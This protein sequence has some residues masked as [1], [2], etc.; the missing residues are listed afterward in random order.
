MLSPTC[1]H[2]GPDADP[3][4]ADLTDAQRQ[5]VVHGGGPLLIVAG[6]GSGKT[7]TIT[8]RIAYLVRGG[9]PPWA[10]LALTF[11][12]K[13]AGEMRARVA[14]LLGDDPAVV[15]GLIVTTFHSLCARLLRQYADGAGVS[16][17]R[18]GFSIYDESDQ[19]AVMKRVLED[20]QLSPGNWSPRSMLAAISAAKNELVD[21]DAFAAGADGFVQKRVAEI[22]RRY[23]R[24]LRS[25]NALDF[26]DLLVFTVRLLRDRGEVLEACRRRW[27]HVLIDEYQ[28]VNRAQFM[29]AAML[30]GASP[31]PAVR[32][33]PHPPNI[34]VVGDSD[35]AIY[36][37]RGADIRNILDFE[38]HFPGARV[39]TLGENFR[40]TGPILAAADRLIRHNRMRRH[41]TLFT[42]QAG[43]EPPRVMLCADEHDEARTVVQWLSELHQRGSEAGRSEGY[44]WRDMA[45]LY[46]VN[47]L[48]R[49]MEEALRQAGIPYVIVRGTAFYEREEVRNILA[50]LRVLANPADDVSLSRIVNV[51]ARGLGEVAMRTLRAQAEARGVSLMEALHRAE[52]RQALGPRGG[53]A[54]GR[55]VSLFEAWSRAAACP[56]DDSH[57]LAGLVER[58]VQ[59]SGLEA[60][61]ARQARVGRAETDRERL[62]N[63]AEVISSAAD[64]EQNGDWRSAGE[65]VEPDSAGSPEQTG[66]TVMTALRAY[67]ES[68]ALVS[69]ADAIDPARGA[70]TLMT[71]HAAK[72]LEF[73]VVAMI[74]LEEGLLPHAR[75]QDDEAAL[76]EERR[77]CFV[78]MTR[79]MRHLHLSAA[80]C[81]TVRGQSEAMLPSR[82]LEEMGAA[83]PA[84]PRGCEGTGRHGTRHGNKDSAD[85]MRMRG[86]MASAGGARPTDLGAPPWRWVRVGGLVRH[87]KFGIGR[88][89]AVTP[90][91]DARARVQFKSAGVRTLVLRYAPL[92]AVE[93][94]EEVAGT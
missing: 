2:T 77:L 5:A 64:F 31:H 14:A 52:V 65:V 24:A 90:G 63:L 82:F 7:R 30:A 89:L 84:G 19:L 58:V 50:Y 13:A 12:N 75:S 16:G 9:V 80:L 15:R 23:E 46:R 73:P 60:M 20:L 67:L 93:A 68:V 11:T 47:A 88:V 59:E 38:L 32:P 45:V 53:P 29:I 43:G 33:V 66:P 42:R 56:L 57:T 4:L 54:A 40:S 61:Y 6:A 28:D 36:G 55:L 69:D 76:E 17:L 21:A 25:A 10:V 78:G 62:E 18:P 48:S 79:A 41:K 87:P 49:V 3:L 44:R 83:A 92:E 94:D 85:G 8:R 51:P 91:T 34:C 1:V 22:Y 86:E 26:D 81:R 71:L 70:V 74:G 39:I 37:W 35:Q 27:R 72:G